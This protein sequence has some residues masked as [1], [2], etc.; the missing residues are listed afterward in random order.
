MLLS[1]AAALVILAS[2]AIQRAFLSDLFAF[3]GKFLRKFKIRR[4]DDRLFYVCCTVERV[5]HR[6]F[7]GVMP[8]CSRNRRAQRRWPVK[9]AATAISE[10]DRSVFACPNLAG[11]F[12][13]ARELWLNQ[14]PRAT[15]N[16]S[17]SLDQ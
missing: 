2:F 11:S 7:L 1:S 8:T 16:N 5:D 13:D 15:L 12:H 4:G 17:T 10:S 3:A 14:A 6:D 9:L